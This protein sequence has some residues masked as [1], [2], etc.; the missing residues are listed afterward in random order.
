[1]KRPNQLVLESAVIASVLIML[2]LGGSVATT[3]IPGSF[4]PL[5]NPANV[6]AQVDLSGLARYYNA[7][8]TQIGNGG[9]AGASFLLDT[10]SFVNIP[11]S[12]NVTAQAANGDLAGLNVTIP[13]AQEAFVSARAAILGNELINATALV[14]R[15]CAIATS[16]DR[17]LADFAGPETARLGS[18]GVPTG[19][20]APGLGLVSQEIGKLAEECSSISSQI[21]GSSTAGPKSLLLIGT[22]QKSVETGGQVTLSGNLTKAGAGVAGQRVLFY[23]NGSYFGSLLTDPNGGLAG[24]LAI[25]FVYAHV[26][27]VQALVAPNSSIGFGGAQSNSILFSILFSQTNIV[28]ADPPAYLPGTAFSVHGNLTTTDGTP[29]PDAPVTV[30]YLRDSVAAT[31]DGTGTFSARFIVPDNATDGV[32]YVYARFTPKGV[33]GPS[34]N[35]TSID[36]F[37]L[38]L[39]LTLS[40]PGLSWAGFSTQLSG[41]A[42]SNG[43]AVANAAIVLSSPWGTSAAKTDQAGHFDVSIPVSP[44]EFGF[45]KSVTVSASPPE[46]YISGTTVVATLALFNILVVILPAAVIVVGVYEA[47][48]LGAFQSFRARIRGRRVQ[49]TALETAAIMPTLEVVPRFEDGPEPLRLFG[50]AL[51]LAATRLSLVFRQSLTIREMLSLVRAKDDGEAY[52]AFAT[53]LLM[54]E[55]FLYG[56]GVGQSRVDEARGALARLEALWP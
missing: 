31:T 43:S 25:P 50:S 27:E 36:V 53:V 54:A 16:A 34:F 56:T 18:E 3:T 28:L 41:T 47:N 24:T 38:R 44:L 21:P 17:I 42:T 46:P 15:G 19:Q 2:T 29:L 20:Y 39:N 32:Y 6:T 35:F 1:M 10:F 48:S 51:A 5:Q 4:L 9:F 13:Q 55:D 12:V 11:S 8:L 26:A 45:S 33:Y 30:T 37:H 52:A 22:G 40:P 23:I 7:T 14:G 49:D